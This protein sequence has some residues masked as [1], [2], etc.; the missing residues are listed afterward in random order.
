MRSQGKLEDPNKKKEESTG[1]AETTMTGI[2]G[3]VVD[4]AFEDK[5]PQDNT[6]SSEVVKGVVEMMGGAFKAVQ[7]QMPKPADP[8]EQADKV[9][10]LIQKLHPPKAEGGDGEGGIVMTVVQM[11]L[12]NMESNNAMLQAM[13]EARINDMKARMDDLK[14]LLLANRANPAAAPATPV[15]AATS[16][17]E[18]V[19]EILSMAKALGLHRGGGGG[20]GDAAAPFDWKASL[21]D[22]MDSGAKL[23]QTIIGAWQMKAAMDARAANPNAPIVIQQPQVQAAPETQPTAPAAQEATQNGNGDAADLAQFLGFIEKPFINHF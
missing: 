19:E 7:D 17:K 22:L 16:A 14:E 6:A 13:N 4:K 10:T 1:M 9:M 8:L 5:P 3:K 18:Y 23:L 11:M 20:V 21:P 15:N 2:L 12:K